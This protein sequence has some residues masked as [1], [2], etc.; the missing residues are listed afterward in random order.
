[1]LCACYL[2]PKFF[3]LEV[4]RVAGARL[5]VDLLLRLLGLSMVPPSGCGCGSVG[6]GSA[7]EE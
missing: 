7:R 3:V 5:Y 1:M 2:L 6:D 4:E